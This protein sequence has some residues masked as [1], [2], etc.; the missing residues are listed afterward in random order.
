M[1]FPWQS[2]FPVVECL[3]H[4]FCYQTLS[5]SHVKNI[6]QT[7]NNVIWLRQHMNSGKIKS[8]SMINYFWKVNLKCSGLVNILNYFLFE[9]R[10]NAL[11]GRISANEWSFTLCNL[12]SFLQS[13]VF[14][15]YNLYQQQKLCRYSIHLYIDSTLKISSNFQINLTQFAKWG[16]VF[17]IKYR[18]LS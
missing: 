15:S 2:C 8:V 13:L 10:Q 18:V 3:A 6:S 16:E 5:F 12:H 9:G 11:L 1:L 4:T 7:S 17:Q 14:L